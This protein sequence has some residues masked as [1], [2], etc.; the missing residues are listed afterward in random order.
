MKPVSHWSIDPFGLSPTMAYLLKQSNITHAVIQRVHYAVKRH[1]AKRKQLEFRWR[2][3]WAGDS[4]KTDVL[5]HMMPFK[6]YDIPRTCGPEPEVGKGVECL[7]F[8]VRIVEF[9]FI[10]FRLFSL[11]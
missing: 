9:V 7:H 3:L 1:L 10:F 11:I 8:F 4:Q 5:T 6:D 2:Q